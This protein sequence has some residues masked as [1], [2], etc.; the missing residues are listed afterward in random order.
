MK[1][2]PEMIIEGVHM[3]VPDGFDQS[4]SDLCSSDSKRLMSGK[5]IKKVVTVKSTFSL[6]WQG[7]EWRKAAELVNAIDGKN[8]LTIKAMDARN[9]YKMTE[10]KIY[11]NDRSCKPSKFDDDGKVYWDIEFKEIEL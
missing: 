7:V 6:K 3:P 8:E 10:F 2:I 5:A 1:W 9:P 4:I 11:V